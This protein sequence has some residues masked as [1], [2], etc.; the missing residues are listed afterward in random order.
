MSE[1]SINPIDATDVVGPDGCSGL[2]RGPAILVAMLMSSSTF[3][4]NMYALFEFGR[5]ATPGTTDPFMQ[6]LSVTDQE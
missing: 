5:W 4:R 1:T 6:I 3:L 2:S